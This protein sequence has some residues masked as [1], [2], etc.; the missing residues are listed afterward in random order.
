MCSLVTKKDCNKGMQLQQSFY[1]G[2]IGYARNSYGLS[3]QLIEWNDILNSF[4]AIPRVNMGY[5]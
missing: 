4:S 5:L 2:Y 3:S 1:V